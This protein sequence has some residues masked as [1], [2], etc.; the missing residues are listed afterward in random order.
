MPQGR[1]EKTGC[2]LGSKLNGASIKVSL[3]PSC[4]GSPLYCVSFLFAAFYSHTQGILRIAV[5][6]S[7]SRAETAPL[8]GMA[9][10]HDTPPDSSRRAFFLATV[11]SLVA[12]ALTIVLLIITM[13]IMSNRPR[14]YYPPYEVYYSFA[15]IAGCS[16]IALVHSGT[17]LIRLRSGDSPSRGLAGILVDVFAGLYF[18]FQSLYGMQQFLYSGSYGCHAPWY[19]DPNRPVDPDCDVWR[20]RAE[21][22]IW[23]YLVAILVF[24]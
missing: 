18:L 4:L 8:L 14:D 10:H 5:I 21:P 22:V 1:I 16:I 24:G 3:C 20:S 13:I 15:P 9:R 7:D 23:C 19:G 17:T 6:M 2:D 12:G 11:A